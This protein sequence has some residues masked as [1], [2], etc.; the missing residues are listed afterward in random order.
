M[1]TDTKPLTAEEFLQHL[2]HMTSLDCC[3]VSEKDQAAIR[4][5]LANRRWLI[6]QR[7]E[8]LGQ[9]EQAAELLLAVRQWLKAAGF[10][11]GK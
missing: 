6:D 9:I 1:T 3:N 11:E 4:W 7:E 2:Q 8:L 5:I 10:G